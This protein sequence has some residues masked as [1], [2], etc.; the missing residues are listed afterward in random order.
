MPNNRRMTAG[1]NLTGRPGA[2]LTPDNY[3]LWFDDDADLKELHPHP[4]GLT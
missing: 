4:A 2:N 3:A 1:T